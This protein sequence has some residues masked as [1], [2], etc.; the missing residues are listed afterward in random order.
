MILDLIFLWSFL[1]WKKCH[2]LSSDNR[3]SGLS[4]Y[5]L[6]ILREL[7]ICIISMVKE[8]C[9]LILS[10]LQFVIAIRTCLSDV[11]MTGCL[12]M[13]CYVLECA[14]VCQGGWKLGEVPRI[15]FR[16]TS[17]TKV[18]NNDNSGDIITN[19]LSK[20]TVK[21]SNIGHP[22]YSGHLFHFEF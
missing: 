20:N 11:F 5:K 8:T 18:L 22:V 19:A 1:W 12:W 2:A 7:F 13:L 15:N 21:L 10:S 14:C 3:C 16:E 6:L 4:A 17:V 9:I